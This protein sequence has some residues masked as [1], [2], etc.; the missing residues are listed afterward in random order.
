MA[1]D[2]CDVLEDVSSSVEAVDISA[3]GRRA[4]A[5]RKARSWTRLEKDMLNGRKETEG[6]GEDRD[7]E[8]QR[9]DEGIEGIQMLR[10]IIGGSRREQMTIHEE[11]RQIVGRIK[12]RGRGRRGRGRKG[13]RRRRRRRRNGSTRPRSRKRKRG[14]S[15]K[16]Q[17]GSVAAKK[18]KWRMAGRPIGPCEWVKRRWRLGSSSAVLGEVG[19]LSA[20]NREGGVGDG[21][22]HGGRGFGTPENRVT[23]RT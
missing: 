9:E 15:G 18:P 6:N 10:A 5:S 1:R 21:R 16:N 12:G 11:K 13:R 2:T 20:A 17:I 3:R 14:R 7:P 19:R 4:G 23:G 22:L 8:I